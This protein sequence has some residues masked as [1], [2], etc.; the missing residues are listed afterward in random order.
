MIMKL[1]SQITFLLLLMFQSAAAFVPARIAN[2]T[3]TKYMCGN[4]SIP[5]PFGIGKDCYM[6]ESF[7]IECDETSNPPTAFLSRVR[8]ELLEISLPNSAV[9]VKVPVISKFN[10]SGVQE[11]APLNLTGTPFFFSPGNSFIAVGCNTRAKFWTGHGS[12]HMGCDSICL[13]SIS[14]ISDWR[15]TFASSGNEDCPDI[16][17]PFKLQDFKSSLEPKEYKQRIEG[18]NQAFLADLSWF[19]GKMIK[20]QLEMKNLT[21]MPILMNVKMELFATDGQDARIQKDHSNASL[22]HF[23]LAF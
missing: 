11:G 15:E 21:S 17:I 8:M 14:N 10:S 18:P 19:E 20:S 9:V 13:D 4:I 5:Y 12:E 22:M 16:S 7:N 1:E 2:S 6:E 23:E 3:C